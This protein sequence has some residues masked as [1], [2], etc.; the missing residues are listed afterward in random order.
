MKKSDDSIESAK[1]LLLSITEDAN[2][3]LKS[4]PEDTEDCLPVWWTN[5]LSISYAYLNSLRDYLLYSDLSEESDELEED[6]YEEDTSPEQ[7]DSYDS[8]DSYYDMLPPSV[9]MVRD[10][11]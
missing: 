10:A 4:L 9:R 11:Y 6:D 3:M 7:P 5:K 2:D 1:R 8:S